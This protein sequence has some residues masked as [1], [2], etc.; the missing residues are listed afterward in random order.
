M[1]HRFLDAK[2][3]EKWKWESAESSRCFW[4]WSRFAGTSKKHCAKV[5]ATLANEVPAKLQQFPKSW[6]N[7]PEFSEYGTTSLFSCGEDAAPSGWEFGTAVIRRKSYVEETDGKIDTANSPA[8]SSAARSK[9]YPGYGV[10][11]F[12]RLIRHG[13]FSKVGVTTVCFQ[14]VPS[15]SR[16]HVSPNGGFCQALFPPNKLFGKI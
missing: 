16:S 11:W 12:H 1:F 13:T 2:L 10:P 5:A 8:S 4:P 9:L 6:P 7:F 15:H 3:Y 14:S